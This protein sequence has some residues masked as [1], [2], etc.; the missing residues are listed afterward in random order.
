MVGFESHLPAKDENKL[1]WWD[2]RKPRERKTIRILR[3]H[4]TARKIHRACAVA[5]VG[6]YFCA[7]AMPLRSYRPPHALWREKGG[8]A[9]L[10]HR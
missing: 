2:G 4:R 1:G 9:R 5:F 3:S 10:K 7:S 6:R 8:F